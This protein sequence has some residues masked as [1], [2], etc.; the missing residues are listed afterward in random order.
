MRYFVTGCA[1]FIGSNLVD[2]L[3][4][5]GHDV[6]GYDNFSTGLPE[7]L[8]KAQQNKNFSLIQ[9]D[10]LI[11]NIKSSNAKYRRSISYGCKC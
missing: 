4:Q 3:L 8:S 2:R 9:G 5:Q 11:R 7:F 6:F 10:L 1:G